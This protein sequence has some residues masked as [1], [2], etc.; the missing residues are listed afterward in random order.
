MVPS[1][2]KA[3]ARREHAARIVTTRAPHRMFAADDAE[4]A[5]GED[6]RVQVG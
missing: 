4:R 2:G 6:A 5:I 1:S 3:I